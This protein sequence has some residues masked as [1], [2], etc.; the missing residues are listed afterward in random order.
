MGC[1]A[2]RKKIIIGNRKRKHWRL[3]TPGSKKPQYPP[4]NTLCL[5]FIK[6]TEHKKAASL[7]RGL[8]HGLK[9]EKILF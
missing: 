6:I 2:S 3:K 7:F 1:S 4:L 8:I 9:N 5:S